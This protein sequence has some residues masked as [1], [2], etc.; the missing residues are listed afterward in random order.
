MATSTFPVDDPIAD[1]CREHNVRLFRGSHDNVASRLLACAQ[2]NGFDWMMRV[3]ADSPYIDRTL[4]EYAWGIAEPSAYDMVTNLYP[5]SYPYGVSVEL[6]KTKLFADSYR[7]MNS[8]NHREHPT[9]YFYKNME[10]F[11]Y[12]NIVRKGDNLNH[13]RLTIDTKEDLEKFRAVVEGAGKDMVSVS[14]GD[15]L[16]MYQHS[17]AM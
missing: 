6:I 17:D 13:L 15:V 8:P 10:R 4:I 5:R 7:K 16:E 11:K 2:Q 12:Y 9:S 3:N 1:F 14:Y